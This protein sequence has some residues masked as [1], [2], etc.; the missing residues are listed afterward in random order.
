MNSII[1]SYGTK[2][3]NI[4]IQDGSYFV[5]LLDHLQIEPFDS[6]S[7]KTTAKYLV[8]LFNNAN[9]NI[10]FKLNYN[11]LKTTPKKEEKIKSLL[12]QEPEINISYIMNWLLLIR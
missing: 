10:E 3:G 7:V 8:Y 9:T 6:K 5:M 4:T 2:I 12:K 11:A 1:F